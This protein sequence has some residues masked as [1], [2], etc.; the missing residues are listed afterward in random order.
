MAITEAHAVRTGPAFVFSCR[1]CGAPLSNPLDGVLLRPHLDPS[2][3][4]VCCRR[5]GLNGP[6]L[7]C[8]RCGGEVGI[9]ISDCWTEYD[10]RLLS[11]A[12]TRTPL[13]RPGSRT[14]GA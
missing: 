2:R 13:D 1:S 4:Y 12:V 11:T 14:S 10:I 9:E 8:A 5:D 7:L 3:L 6:K